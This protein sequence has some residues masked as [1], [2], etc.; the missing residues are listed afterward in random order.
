MKRAYSSGKDIFFCGNYNQKCQEL[1]FK[2]HQTSNSVKG[3]NQHLGPD[4][5]LNSI[6]QMF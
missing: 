1:F 5:Y 2:I 6:N 4:L 3:P